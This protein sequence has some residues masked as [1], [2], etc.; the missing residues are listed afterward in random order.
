MCGACRGI[1]KDEGLTGSR[2]V[3]EKG[4][5]WRL[6]KAE[7]APSHCVSPAILTGYRYMGCIILTKCNFILTGNRPALTYL[8][9]LRSLLRIHNETVNIW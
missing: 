6:M 9:C 1:T 3:R 5:G 7:E 4:T 8:A 2:E